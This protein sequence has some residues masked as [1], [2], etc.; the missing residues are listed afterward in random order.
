MLT[1]ADTP[2][3]MRV[4]GT[5]AGNGNT[6]NR[7]RE[8]CT[9]AKMLEAATLPIRGQEEKSAF[10]IETVKIILDPV[11]LGD[12]SDHWLVSSKSETS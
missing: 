5:R 10:T 2:P 1:D 7:R 3:T 8:S 6:P 11:W 4:T 12:C 9:S